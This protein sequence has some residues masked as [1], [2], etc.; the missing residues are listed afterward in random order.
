MAFNYISPNALKIKSLQNKSKWRR[1]KIKLL[2]SLLTVGFIGFIALVVG[3][4]G[5]F[6]YYSKDLPSPNKLTERT[7]EQATKIYDRSGE[8]LYDVYGDQNRTLVSLKDIPPYLVNATIATEDKNF[9]KHQG[10]DIEGYLRIFENVLLRGNVIGG[11]TITQQLVKNALL[12][13][14]R[15]LARKLKELVLAIQ[16]ERKYSK[17]DIL[18]IY[19][20]EVPYGGTAWGVES[21][22]ELYFG[23]SVKDLSLVESAVLAGL[24]QSPTRYS[25]FGDN[26][27]AYIDRTKG[28]LRRMR[29]D[30]YINKDQE[31]EAKKELEGYKFAEPKSTLKAPHFVL[32]VK[33]QLVEKYGESL[34]ETGGLRVTTSLDY[35]LQKEVEEIVRGELER[36]ESKALKVGNAASII[37]D[38]KT[39]AILVMVGSKDYFADSFPEGCTPGRNCQFEPNV[40]VTTSSR[41]PGSSIKPL[42]YLTGFKKGFNAATVLIDVKTEFPN[43][44]GQKP[45]APVNYDGKFHGPVQVRYALGNSYN[46]PAVKMLKNVSVGEMLKT[47]YEMGIN[48]YEP[49]VENLSRFGLALTLGGGELKLVELTNAYS[50]IA[51]GGNRV[52][53]VTILKVTD[54]GGRVIEEFKPS[55]GR[56]VLTAEDAWI[57]TDVLADPTAKVDAFGGAAYSILSVKGHKVAVKT[58]TTDDK[59]DNW[60]MGYSPSYTV[61]VWV[62]NND[63]TLLD[64]RLSSGITGAAPIWNKVF[65]RILKDKKAEDWAKPAKIVQLDVDKISGLLP[66]PNTTATRKEYFATWSQPKEVDYFS[67][68]I[69]ICKTTGREATAECD[70]AQIEEKVFVVPRDADGQIICSDNCPPDVSNPNT[71]TGG[72]AVG[73]SSPPN[74]AAVGTSFDVIANASGPNQIVKVEFIFDGVPLKTLTSVPYTVQFQL[75]NSVKSGAHQ[76]GARATDVAGNMGTTEASITVSN[77]ANP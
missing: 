34:V 25:P 22:S 28:V 77:P 47:S 14:D 61:G 43:G 42:T 70:P 27:T 57:M 76:V 32:M 62:G 13:S 60:T 56:Q 65:T 39:G 18:Q 24:P 52:D 37:Q 10:F 46:I 53:P 30:G 72:V 55:K 29:E 48:S 54:S 23:K 69:R 8:L 2:Q 71:S 49:T 11:S 68:K 12:T 66:G 26:P 17:D 19:L 44:I 33:R 58:G 16:I 5:A 41:Q 3:V 6:A 15:T 7:I 59:K 50:V 1:R 64:P 38:P 40:N 63:G 21:A 67:R 9:K 75:G 51:N 4:I 36:P 31:D 74:G 35:K 73:I 45:Y 20:N